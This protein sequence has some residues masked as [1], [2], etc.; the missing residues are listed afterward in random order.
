MNIAG[1]NINL[2][3]SKCCTSC[4]TGIVRIITENFIQSSAQ[5]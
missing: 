4:C 2:T 5:N 1:S 3:Y